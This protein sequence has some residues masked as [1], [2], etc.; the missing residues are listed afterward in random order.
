M[1]NNQNVMVKKK[2][3][4]FTLVELVA[5]V[6]I[7]GILA[8]ILVPKVTSYMNEAKKVKV[9]DQGRKVITAIES[10]NMKKDGVGVISTTDTT[11]SVNDLISNNAT[12]K[13]FVTGGANSESEY[14]KI[15]TAKIGEI[16]R[17]VEKKEDFKIDNTGAFTA[18]VS[19]TN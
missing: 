12:I 13:E 16:Y 6:A 7:I 1:V 10:Y 17:I 14:D 8:A 19:T 9:I 4:G 3:K 18:M 5:V 11:T 15:K 2:K